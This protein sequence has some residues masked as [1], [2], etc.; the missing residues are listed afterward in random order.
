MLVHGKS[1]ALNGV[2]A[3]GALDDEAAQFGKWDC[4]LTGGNTHIPKF[5]IPDHFPHFRASNPT[6]PPAKFL[7]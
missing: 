5:A 1:V 4:D 6:P 2:S 3:L 7:H